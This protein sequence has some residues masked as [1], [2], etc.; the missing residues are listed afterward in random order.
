MPQSMISQ[1]EQHY[2]PTDNV[3]NEGFADV[4]SSVAGSFKRLYQNIFLGIKGFFQ[5]MPSSPSAKEWKRFFEQSDLTYFD[6]E[7][8]EVP[9]AFGQATNNMVMVDR[10]LVRVQVI[11]KVVANSVIPMASRYFSKIVQSPDLLRNDVPM[12]SMYHSFT[13]GDYEREVK[14]DRGLFNGDSK[15]EKAKFGDLNPS[16]GAFVQMLEKLEKCVRDVNLLPSLKRIDRDVQNLTTLL[17]R[18]MKEASNFGITTGLQDQLV[19]DIE[20]TAKWVQ[21]YALTIQQIVA[22]CEVQKKTCDIIKERSEK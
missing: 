14:L 3:S 15:V 7:D 22:F 1:L 17:D 20:M 9:V 12:A 4:F 5:T 18:V 21:Y 6:I 11:E 10:F 16:N 13:A 19:N 2:F 8:L